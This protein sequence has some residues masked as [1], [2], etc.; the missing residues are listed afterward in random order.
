MKHDS[1]LCRFSTEIKGEVLN[2][3]VSQILKEFY[4]DVNALLTNNNAISFAFTIATGNDD[5][6]E[7]TAMFQYSFRKGKK[8][9]KCFHVRGVQASKHFTDEVILPA[10]Y[11]LVEKC[12]SSGYKI[13]EDM[14]R[15]D[16]API[17]CRPS[18]CVTVGTVTEAMNPKLYDGMFE[19][20][21]TKVGG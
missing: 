9:D 17:V 19:A 8:P 7:D 10:Y 18:K 2:E 11:Y 15:T 16:G 12:V 3:S 20:T 4:N 1:N 14:R 5:T 13:Q 21:L 6:T